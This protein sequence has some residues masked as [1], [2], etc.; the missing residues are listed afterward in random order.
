M[1]PTKFCEFLAERSC[2]FC[3]K[4]VVRWNFFAYTNS[5]HT[6][7]LNS[8]SESCI[9]KNQKFSVIHQS[10]CDVFMVVQ[11]PMISIYL[12]AVDV[13]GVPHFS[14][15]IFLIHD[16]NS[17]S[18][19]GRDDAGVAPA[20]GLSL[21]HLLVLTST[22]KLKTEKPDYQ[23]SRKNLQCTHEFPSA[24]FLRHRY[25]STLISYKLQYSRILL[26]LVAQLDLKRCFAVLLISKCG[27]DDVTLSVMTLVL[28][29]SI[30]YSNYTIIRR[31]D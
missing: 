31:R 18:K 12:I 5:P 3:F 26:G 10:N 6:W 16:A 23:P 19:C 11:E 25:V 30:W 14:T 22:T 28:F 15:T 7:S 1:A 27:D 2:M 29:K 21:R 8:V 13:D 20:L 17:A 24:R 9:W 4:F